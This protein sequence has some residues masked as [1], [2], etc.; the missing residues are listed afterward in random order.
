MHPFVRNLLLFGSAAVSLGAAFAPTLYAQDDGPPK[1]LVIDREYLKPGKN[2]AM[3]DRTESAIV[4]AFTDAKAPYYYFALDSLSGPSRSLFMFSY[5]SFAAWQKEMSEIRSN[6]ALASKLDRAAQEDGDLLSLYESA[7]AVLRPDLSLNKGSINGTRFFELTV[8]VVKPGYEHDFE[9]LAKIYVDTWRK[10]DPE[11]HWDT[12]EV[13]YGNPAP[14]IAGGD[15][16]IVATTLKS[17]AETDKS[18]ANDEKFASTAGDD[19][20]KK[21]RELTA[22]SVASANTNLFAINPRMSNPRPEWV[23]NEPGFWKV[24]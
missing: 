8:F 12:F 6:P 2:G 14:T 24:P 23:K 5:D 21:I 18:L 4:K 19:T 1:V 9:E 3:H 22:A 15:I 10:I 7:A 17:L 20:M 16:F 13:M 11:T